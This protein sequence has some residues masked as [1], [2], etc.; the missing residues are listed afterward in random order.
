MK[1][2]LLKR[3]QAPLNTSKPEQRTRPVRVYA[4]GSSSTEILDYIFGDTPRYKSLWASGWSARGLRKDTNR[5]FIMKCLRAARPQDIIFLHFGVVDAIFNA[6]YRAEK[7]DFMDPEGFC[8]EAADGV[9]MLVEDLKTAGFENVYSLCMGPPSPLRP[10]Y[11][12]RRAK[13]LGLPVRYQARL[14]NRMNELVGARVRQIDMTPLLADEHGVLRKEFRRTPQNHHADYTKTQ[15]VI[16]EALS[17]I[18]DL[19]PRQPVWHEK[20]YHNPKRGG[21][22]KLLKAERFNGANLS[23]F[24]PE[25]NPR[26]WGPEGRAERNKQQNKTSE[27]KRPENKRPGQKRRKAGKDLGE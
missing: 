2:N 26:L 16:W 25:R 7:G 19:P 10:N 5:D 21:V 6:A 12:Q 23:R 27:N 17:E 4:F 13:M 1:L 24:A 22:G 8:Q 20:L 3:D 9:G 14:L 18:P 15:S 11:F